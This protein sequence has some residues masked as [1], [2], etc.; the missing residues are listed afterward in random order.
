MGEENKIKES[1]AAPA[2]DMIQFVS[3]G[4]C[5]YSCS[6]RKHNFPYLPLL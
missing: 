1:G 5:I 3:Y 6:V 2:G 4:R